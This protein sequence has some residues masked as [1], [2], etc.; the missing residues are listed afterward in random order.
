VNQ[1]FARFR[2]RDVACRTSQQPKAESCLQAGNGVT[3]MPIGNPRALRRPSEATLSCDSEEC[4]NIFKIF[5]RVV[6]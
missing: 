3:S 6:S 5:A 1:A 4:E 2:R